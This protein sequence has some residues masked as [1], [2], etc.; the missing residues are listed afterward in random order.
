MQ[1]PNLFAN[2]PSKLAQE[3]FEALLVGQQFRLERIVSTGQATPLGQWY[4]QDEHEWVLLLSGEAELEFADNRRIRLQ[5]GDHV[6]IP[7]HCRHRV[8]FTSEAHPTVW[9]ALFFTPTV[10]PETH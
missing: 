2:L 5:P 1:L 6:Q 7:A 8:S 9:L 3:Q 10:S 4:D